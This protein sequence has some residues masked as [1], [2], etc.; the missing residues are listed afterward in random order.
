L[1][2]VG[3]FGVHN[4]YFSARHDV[5]RTREQSCQLGNAS[6]HGGIPESSVLVA[7]RFK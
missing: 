4:D 5:E 3:I 6:A 1:R 2:Q 7:F